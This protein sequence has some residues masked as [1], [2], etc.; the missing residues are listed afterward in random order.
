MT[1]LL[2]HSRKQPRIEERYS[3]YQI[4]KLPSLPYFYSWQVSLDFLKL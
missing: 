3:L 4:S 1:L 2:E